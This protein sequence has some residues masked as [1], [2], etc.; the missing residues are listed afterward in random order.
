MIRPRTSIFGFAILFAALLVAS[1]LNVPSAFAQTGTASISG[2]VPDESNGVMPDVEVEIKNVDPAVTQS[3]K[4]NGDGVHSLP[5]LSPGHYLMSV[6]KQQFRTV[7]VTG[8]TLNVQDNLSRNFVLQVGSSAESV[9]VSGASVNINTTDATVS[10]VIDRDFVA[11]IPL[12]GRSFQDLLTLVPGVAQ[13]TGAGVGQVGEFT[14]NGQRTE[15]NSFSVDG[16]SANVGTAPGNFG[17]TAGIGGSTAAE[18][19]FGTTQSM[20]SIDALQEF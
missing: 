3:T 14:V 5:A 8:I 15:A 7:S 4:T 18:T 12:N 17:A 20:V 2:R 11:N 16:V 10:T 9:T 1:L 13:M 6:R 19:V